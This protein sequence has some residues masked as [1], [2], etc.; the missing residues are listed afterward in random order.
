[1]SPIELSWTAKNHSLL[2]PYMKNIFLPED[3]RYSSLQVL[4]YPICLAVN[5]ILLV[6]LYLLVMLYL[7]YYLSTKCLKSLFLAVPLVLYSP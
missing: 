2:K 7:T 3:V 5:T 6:T 1:M 4:G